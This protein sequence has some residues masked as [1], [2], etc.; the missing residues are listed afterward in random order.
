MAL[1][2]KSADVGADAWVNLGT[3]LSLADDSWYELEVQDTMGNGQGWLRVAKT[4][5][6]TAPDADAG[7]SF[8]YPRTA[9][10]D[11]SREVL[12]KQAAVHIWGRSSGPTMRVVAN[13]TYARA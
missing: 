10:A 11:A 2:T 9:G 7:A 5:D 4:D 8:R 3:A 6:N 1:L 12:K 13:P